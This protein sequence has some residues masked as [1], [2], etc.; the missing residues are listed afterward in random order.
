MSENNAAVENHHSTRQN[1]DDDEDDDYRETVALL[2]FSTITDGTLRLERVLHRLDYGT[3]T[4][5]IDY[6]RRFTVSA[7]GLLHVLMEL[8][9]VLRYMCTIRR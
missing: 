9:G 3:I 1:Y 8:L 7:F 2:W 6:R 5:Y 4:M